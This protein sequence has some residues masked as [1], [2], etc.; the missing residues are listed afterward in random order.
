[1]W[2]SHRWM[3]ALLQLLSERTIGYILQSDMCLDL[4]RRVLKDFFSRFKWM[5]IWKIADWLRLGLFM[6]EKPGQS[7]KCSPS[8]HAEKLFWA[9]AR[10]FLAIW[11]VLASN[12]IFW[13]DDKSVTS[14]VSLEWMWS[15]GWWFP[16]AK[17]PEESS[18]RYA[19]RNM[20]LTLTVNGVYKRY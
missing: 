10:S 16:P 2:C 20:K 12:R 15:Q 19:R 7:R 13:E 1:M 8:K 6:L 14:N 18:F 11:V 4:S 3:M 17:D 5:R 9:T